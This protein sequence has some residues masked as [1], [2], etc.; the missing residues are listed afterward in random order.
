MK[1]NMNKRDH[2]GTLRTLWSLEG[3]LSK[4]GKTKTWGT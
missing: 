1:E 4:V 3:A 2:I